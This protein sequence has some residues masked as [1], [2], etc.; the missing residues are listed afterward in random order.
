MPRALALAKLLVL[1]GGGGG[2]SDSS[3]DA[4]LA[5]ALARG[6]EGAAYQGFLKFAPLVRSN[7]R[8]LLGP[9]LD[10]DDLCQEVFL[11]FYRGIP[12]LRDPAA[13]RGFLFGICWRVGRGEL[14]RRWMRRWLRLSDDGELPDRPDDASTREGQP[15]ARE[16]LARYYRVLDSISVAARSLFVSRYLEGAELEEVARRH[17]LSLS[18]AQRRLARVTKLVDAMIRRDPILCELADQ[19]DKPEQNE[20]GPS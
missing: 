11:R 18:T 16:A 1:H 10:E 5:R 12:R 15:D 3:G 6:D 14:R 7:L 19:H 9:G 2:K 4:E 17:G 13:L 20:K 8:R